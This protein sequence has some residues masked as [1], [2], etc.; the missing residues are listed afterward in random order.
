MIISYV[1]KFWLFASLLVLTSEGCSTRAP[2][3]YSAEN[4]QKTYLITTIIELLENPLDYRDSIV[5]IQGYYRSGFEK[6]ALYATKNDYIN[7]NNKRAIWIGFH[8]NLS[9]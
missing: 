6:S 2:I 3:I 7:T 9:I 8:E 1:I 4:F 5:E